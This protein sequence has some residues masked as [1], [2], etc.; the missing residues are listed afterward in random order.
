MKKIVIWTNDLVEKNLIVSHLQKFSRDATYA[1]RYWLLHNPLAAFKDLLCESGDSIQTCLPT[2]GNFAPTNYVFL[3][4]YT[5][6][7]YKRENPDLGSSESYASSMPK[8][9]VSQ[10]PTHWVRISS[11]FPTK[12]LPD[13]FCKQSVQPTIIMATELEVGNNR[14]KSD[15]LL[16]SYLWEKERIYIVNRLWSL[17]S[18]QTLWVSIQSDISRSLSDYCENT[19]IGTK[20]DRTTKSIPAVKQLSVSENKNVLTLPQKIKRRTLAED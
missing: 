1:L 9:P 2:T 7:F 18:E 6:I 20:Y 4:V 15:Q 14:A 17:Y 3:F 10:V 12:G 16:A 5:R 13:I 11:C 19:N 8:R